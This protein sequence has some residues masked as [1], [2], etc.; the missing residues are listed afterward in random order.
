MEKIKKYKKEFEYTYALGAFPS[1]EGLKSLDKEDILKVFIHSTYHEKDSLIER[2]NKENILYSISDSTIR[3]LSG[4]DKNLV[5]LVIK[6]NLEGVKEEN[7]VVLEGVSNMGNLGTIIRT[8]L[9]MN[10][11]DIVTIGNTCDIYDPKVIRSS[12]GA[13]FKVRFSH[14]D[15][16]EEY[17]KKYLTNRDKYF[18]LLNEKAE[19]LNDIEIDKN[20]KIS[21]VFGNEGSGLKRDYGEM[22]K[23]VYIPQSDDVDSLNLPIS[24]GIGLFEFTNRR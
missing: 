13:I 22:G 21:L 9:A 2:L 18:F 12:M 14:F 10:I 19:K 20:K 4:N 1:I 6:K 11:K 5:I 23:A 8:S 3:R 24:V 17:H 7:H 16:M 15:T